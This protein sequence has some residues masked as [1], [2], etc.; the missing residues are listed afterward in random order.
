MDKEMK[1]VL[2]TGM[3][4]NA[5][6]WYDFVLFVQFA[7]FIGKLFFPAG[8]DNAALLAVFGVFAAGFIMRPVGGVLFGYIGDKLGRKTSLVLSIL[9][10]SIPTAAIGVLPTYAAIGIFA[11]IC[12]TLIRLLQGL[13]LG[14]GFS[15]CMTF[16]VEYAPKDKR[17]LI[18]SAS[19]FSLGAGVLL[20]ILIARGTHSLIATEAFELWGWRIPFLLSLL[21]GSVAFY[22]R[23]HVEESPVYIQA[24]KL[25][26]LS[27]AP[28]RDVLKN[29]LKPL[30]TA[31]GI[32]L[33]VTVPF[34]TLSAFFNTFMQNK[35]GYSLS[36]AM[37]INGIALVFFMMAMPI[38]GYIS[39]R[40]GRKKTLLFAAVSI[41]LAAYP[42]FSLIIQGGTFGPLMGQIIFGILVGLY[43]GP[44]PAVLVE[45]FPTSVR[46]TGLALSYNISAALFGGTV[47]YVYMYLIQYTESLLAP[48]YYIIFFVLMTL[49]TIH[50]YED[51]YNL[52][53]AE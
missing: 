18:G 4:G 46:F 19:M 24:K 5:L 40:I 43:M 36:E 47:P 3:I 7:P 23:S 32:Y 10:M 41:A 51:N 50:D 42:C 28:V 31:I 11:P 35:L 27:K 22:I 14:G 49:V 9:L 52:A 29:Y 26:K 16:L 48:S 34:Y 38:S 39:D 44:V 8:N 6:E 17:G 21:I 13:A 20:G 30:I 37:T 2:I 45:L 53:L 15:G 25:G 33:T 12:L 1:K